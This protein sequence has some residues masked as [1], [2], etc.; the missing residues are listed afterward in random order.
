M[1][2]NFDF[3]R[4]YDVSV[5]AL[6]GYVGRGVPG[7]TILVSPKALH[8]A[9]TWATALLQVSPHLGSHIDLPWA[10]GGAALEHIGALEALK[11]MAESHL[12]RNPGGGRAWKDI[13]AWISD[14]TD[15]L[16]IR[17]GPDPRSYGLRL[18]PPP[19]LG[20][21]S[22]LQPVLPECVVLDF[23]C[24]AAKMAEYTQIWRNGQPAILRP[25]MTTEQ[26]IQLVSSLCITS[27]AVK[28]AMCSLSKDGLKALQGKLLVVRTG[29]SRTF[30]PPDDMDMAAPRFEGFLPWLL[31]P[32]LDGDSARWLASSVGVWGVAIDCLNLENP[33]YYATKPM[34]RP[35]EEAR[36][37]LIGTERFP[38]GLQLSHL[39]FLWRGKYLIE[40][41]A[42]VGCVPSGKHARGRAC[43]LPF[44]VSLLGDGVFVRVFLLLDY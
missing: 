24:L 32:Y 27:E 14:V 25:D 7:P 31:H 43:L 29:W 2:V 13:Y 30:R 4:A 6:K 19:R 38:R 41:I 10:M 42:D 5:P 35:V 16:E 23:T 36:A 3:A 39:N 37:I 11:H 40:N 17:R 1:T 21:K 22:F 8:D 9:D 26:V 28:D 44:P 34:W 20:I 12:P 33:L 15:R 18:G